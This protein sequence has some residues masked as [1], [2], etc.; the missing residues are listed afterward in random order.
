LLEEAHGILLDAESGFELMRAYEELGKLV[1]A[2]TVGEKLVALPAAPKDSPRGVEAQ[3]KIKDS[4][5]A[6]ATRVSTLQLQIKR[7]SK[8]LIRVKVD[9]RTLLP[10]QLDKPIRVNPGNH[11]LRVTAPGYEPLIIPKDIDKGVVQQYPVTIDMVP[12][13]V[14]KDEGIHVAPP[15]ET[16][17]QP[18]A[19]LVKVGIVVSGALGAVALVTGIA[20]GVSYTGFVDAYKGRGCGADCD[21]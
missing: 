3:R 6:L 13:P 14:P 16:P 1:E 21:A 19:P 7:P 4:L 15:Q 17:A 12:I 18:L 8:D 20:A 5:T 9:E 2:I 10:E 11:E